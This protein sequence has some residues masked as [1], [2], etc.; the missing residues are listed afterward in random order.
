MSRIATVIENY[1]S[2]VP[3]SQVEGEEG[4]RCTFDS[5]P[6]TQSEITRAF[7]EMELPSDLLAFWEISRSALLFED[8]Q[9]GQW[10]L[11]ILS[12]ER[13]SAMTSEQLEFYDHGDYR[14]GD[15]VVGEF[16]GDL[17]LLVLNTAPNSQDLLIRAELDPREQ[18]ES[19]ASSLGEFLEKFL[20]T[21]SRKFWN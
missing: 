15:I 6:A 12:P 14:P 17:E 16:L 19:P 4:L 9:F 1:R 21:P 20:A 10:G 13:C 11:R 5:E 18:W 2:W 3:D 7:N 8:T